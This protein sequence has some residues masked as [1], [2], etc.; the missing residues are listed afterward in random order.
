MKAVI[1]A[2]GLGSRLW[3]KTDKTPK[4]LLPYKDGTI[5]S[6]IIGNFNLI[7]ISNF[8]LVV[9]YQAHCIEKYIMDRDYKTNHIEFVA[10]KEW[11]KGNGISVLAVESV[12]KSQSFILSMSDHIVSA[13]ALKRVADAET[14]YNYLLVDPNIKTVFDIADATKVKCDDSRIIDIGKEIPTY[15]AIDCG[16]FKLTDRYFTSMKEALS[17]GEDSISS[18]IKIL[19][20]NDDMRAVFVQSG[21]RWMDIDTPEAYQHI[22]KNPIN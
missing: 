11:E 19:I 12:L 18:A 8:I 20:K 21:D 1:I 22:L 13:N 15:D 5:L 2:A 17:R 4:T 16:V 9:G 14:G 10:N 6:N 3:A 7:G